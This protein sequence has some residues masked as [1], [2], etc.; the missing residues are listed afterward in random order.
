MPTSD[1]FLKKQIQRHIA[2]EIIVAFLYRSEVSMRFQVK[3]QVSAKGII[4]SSL[5]LSVLSTANYLLR[6]FQSS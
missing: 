5:I 6:P 2:C 3:I 1:W 4:A